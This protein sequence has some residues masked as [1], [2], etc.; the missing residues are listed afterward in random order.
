MSIVFCDERLSEEGA[1]LSGGWIYLAVL[2]VC[3]V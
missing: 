2:V 3:E 1:P